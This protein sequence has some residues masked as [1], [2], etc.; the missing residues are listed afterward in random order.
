[1]AYTVEFPDRQVLRYS[2]RVIQLNRLSWRDFLRQ[3]NPVAVALMTKMRVAREDRP[4]VKLECLRLLVTLKLDPA[5]MT[6]IRGFLDAYLQLNASELVE[7]TNEVE[8]I[9]PEEREAV[10]QSVNEWEARGEARGLRLG[11]LEMLIDLLESQ[12]GELPQDVRDRL[13][14]LHLPELKALTL[15]AG[16]MGDVVGLRVWLDALKNSV[17]MPTAWVRRRPL[18]SRRL[19]RLS[20]MNTHCRCRRTRQ[21]S[22]TLGMPPP[23]S[24]AVS[25]ARR[26][27]PDGD[28]QSTSFL[29]R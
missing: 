18:C 14:T 23:C 12:L 8:K 26:S 21:Q 17:T 13:W 1:M 9:E 20:A 7:Y 28:N 25:L 2:Y 5:R 22:L 27:T 24:A 29:P 16:K 6:L 19:D 11:R 15:A 10:M 4:R 3:R